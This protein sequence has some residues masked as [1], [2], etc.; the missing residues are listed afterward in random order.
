MKSVLDLA[1][2]GVLAVQLLESSGSAARGTGARAGARRLA[3]ST[4]RA[5]RLPHHLQRKRSLSA[6]VEFCAAQLRA[7]GWKQFVR[8]LL[9]QRGS[10][11][12]PLR[13]GV[14]G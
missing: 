12:V 10:M 2:F 5:R 3:A 6:S 1:A 8:T 7:A 14:A 9:P 4:H 13:E 11:P